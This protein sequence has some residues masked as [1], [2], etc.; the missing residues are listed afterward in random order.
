M[1]KS[2]LLSLC[3]SVLLWINFTGFGYLAEI[4]KLTLSVNF[5]I[6]NASVAGIPVA[7]L[8]IWL[9]T[10]APWLIAGILC[11][12]LVR[13][14]WLHWL[15]PLVYLLAA[16]VAFYLAIRLPLPLTINGV[17]VTSNLGSTFYP[18]TTT[19]AIFALL[20]TFTLVRL[21]LKRT[22]SKN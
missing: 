21:L 15:T 9:L 3:T 20:A 10:A 16:F 13:D 19:I 14:R 22:R 5:Q 6:P 18:P 1:L 7:Y 12:L 2:F 17:H 8:Y 11:A 4:N